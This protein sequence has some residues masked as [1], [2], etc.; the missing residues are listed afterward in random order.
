MH[1]CVHLH[2]LLCT[3]CVCVC[4]FV[5]VYHQNS[6]EGIG[7]PGSGVAGGSELQDVGAGN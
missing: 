4:T 5:C 7:F 2:A 1:A 3:V 6:E